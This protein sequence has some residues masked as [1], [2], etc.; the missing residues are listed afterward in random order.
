[1]FRDKFQNEDIDKC[2]PSC[3]KESCETDVFQEMDVCVP[4]SIEP[5]VDLGEAEVE[6]IEDPYIDS[7]HF[8]KCN[9]NETCKFTIYQKIC[10]MI[11]V[12]FKAI[13]RSGS[14]SVICGDISD[15]DCPTHICDEEGYFY[16]KGK[17]VE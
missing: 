15:E 3:E 11:P 6:C 17:M 2:N 1:M 13:A 9:K 8:C 5:Y 10:V 7:L 14:T 4:I 16:I 12:E